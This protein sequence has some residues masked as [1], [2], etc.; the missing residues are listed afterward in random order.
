M[1]LFYFILE[2]GVNAYGDRQETKVQKMSR[3]WRVEWKK[4]MTESLGEGSEGIMNSE[5]NIKALWG[6]LYPFI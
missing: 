6:A 5:K 4:K 3:C 1:G 2:K